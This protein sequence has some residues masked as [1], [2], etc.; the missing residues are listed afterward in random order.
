MNATQI[1]SL[2]RTLNVVPM[3][4]YGTVLLDSGAVT[5]LMYLSFADGLGFCANSADRKTNIPDGTSSVLKGRLR[6]ILVNLRSLRKQLNLLVVGEPPFD[7]IIRLS[8]LEELQTIL[9]LGNRNLP[10]T[11]GEETS[12][13]DLDYDYKIPSLTDSGT[14]SD[15]FKSVSD[16]ILF[17]PSSES[18]SVR[19]LELSIKDEIPYGPDIFEV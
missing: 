10:L 17:S 8:T 11:I 18:E 12:F 9:E 5:S 6:N 16:I 14:D 3:K 4:V 15:D 7:V 1:Y 13:M 2:T 19:N